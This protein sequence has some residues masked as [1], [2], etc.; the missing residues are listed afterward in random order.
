MCLRK[1]TS[2]FFPYISIILTQLKTLLSHFYTVKTFSFEKDRN[3]NLRNRNF[4]FREIILKDI[5]VCLF[6]SR[7]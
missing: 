6:V 3:E 5:F 4:I 1:H 7:E 2:D